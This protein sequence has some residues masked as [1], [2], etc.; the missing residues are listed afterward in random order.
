MFAKTLIYVLVGLLLYACNPKANTIP[1]SVELNVSN[2][3]LSS[4]VN[5]MVR[6][7]FGIDY[8]T[9]FSDT[10]TLAFQN[11]AAAISAIFTVSEANRNRLDLNIP[12][13]GDAVQMVEGRPAMLTP[14]AP[15]L[16]GVSEHLAD[17]SSVKPF[18]IG[19][20]LTDYI[21]EMIAS[22]TNMDW[23][24]QSIPG[25]PLRWQWQ[26]MAAADLGSYP[27]HEVTF[28]DPDYG[29]PRGDYSALVLTESVPRN[30][31]NIEDTLDYA[32][33]FVD[34]ALKHNPASRIYIYEVWHCVYS[35]TRKDCGEDF[36]SRTWR[37]RLDDDLPMWNSLVADLN[38]RFDTV[39]PICLIPGGQG[40]ARL[41]D[42]MMAG[43]VP[44]LKQIE[45]LF[46]DDI[47]LN[48]IG[49]YFVSALH[50]GILFQE[51]PVGLKHQVYNQ[52]GGLF[53]GPNQ[54]QATRLQQIALDTL[55]EDSPCFQP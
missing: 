16:F 29:L 41:Y 52:W 38:R 39:Q 6:L 10:A 55:V 46:E 43:T 24:F 53:A 28:Y 7:S 30:S 36:D 4:K 17:G 26:R 51:S 32:G 15:L 21:P 40:L 47:H 34:Y 12:Q 8:S 20:S 18:Y 3:S 9:G 5:E 2:V 33:R 45:D 50:Y 14:N 42:A 1:S 23:G 19:H 54:Q 31:E 35:G 25:A 13:V 37:Q 27:P 49:R 11:P 44:D 22:W 48:D